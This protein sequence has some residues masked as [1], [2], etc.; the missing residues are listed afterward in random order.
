MITGVLR[1]TTPAAEVAAEARLRGATV[2]VVASADERRALLAAIGR[3]LR[4]PARSGPDLAALADALGDLS[5]LPAGEVV[6]VWDGSDALRLS[7]PR[8]HRTL[9]EVLAA[10]VE[11]TADGARPLR[12]VLSGALVVR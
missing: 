10:A 1:V 9:L 12:V 6:L 8:G 5:W 11:A 3:A 4:F 2:G 7:D